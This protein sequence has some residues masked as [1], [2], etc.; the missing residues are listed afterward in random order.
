MEEAIKHRNNY[1]D[2]PQSSAKRRE[3][4]SESIRKKWEDETYRRKTLKGM[5][6]YRD[7]LPPKP[8]KP[9]KERT[10][11]KKRVGATTAVG[12]RPIGRKKKV[13]GAKKKKVKR[14]SDE[15]DDD[16]MIVMASAVSLVGQEK[17]KAVAEEIKRNAEEDALKEEQKNDGVTS[18]LTEGSVV[19]SAKKEKRDIKI[20]K[21][22]KKKDGDISVMREERRDLYD[23]LYGDE[24]EKK[25]SDGDDDDS[26]ENDDNV[27][28]QGD[29][30]G[31][32]STFLRG[33]AKQYDDENLDNFDP[34]GLEDF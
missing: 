10:V 20:K 2:D 26:G 7:T 19:E 32:S 22:G 13:G 30:L 17:R 21:K 3:R 34:Y 31:D 6:A 24:D 27:D 9:K 16:A 5:S 12:G 25:S 11:R 8:A 23:L 33:I 18:E 14:K 29:L 1:A 15:D 28:D 4:I